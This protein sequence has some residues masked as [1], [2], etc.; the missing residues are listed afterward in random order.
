MYLPF[1]YYLSSQTMASQHPTTQPPRVRWCHHRWTRYLRNPAPVMTECNIQRYP[2][3]VLSKSWRWRFTISIFTKT[4]WCTWET[5]T[6]MLSN[7]RSSVSSFLMWNRCLSSLD[8]ISSI[9]SCLS[10]SNFFFLLANNDSISHSNKSHWNNK[11]LLKTAWKH[12]WTMPLYYNTIMYIIT[13]VQ[14]RS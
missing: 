11:E 5:S 3:S 8:L 9:L 13:L 12:P 4:L 7:I 14:Y 1:H 6:D 10:L 2:V